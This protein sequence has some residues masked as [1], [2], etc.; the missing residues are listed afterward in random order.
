MFLW[1]ILMRLYVFDSP[2]LIICCAYD[3][4]AIMIHLLWWLTI[5]NDLFAILTHFLF[6]LTLDLILWLITSLMTAFDCAWLHSIHFFDS[7]FQQL[8]SWLGCDSTWQSMTWK[9]LSMIIYD[10]GATEHDYA[11][12]GS[13]RAW[14]HSIHSYDSL[15]DFMIHSFIMTLTEE[16]LM[17]CF[18]LYLYSPV[19]FLWSS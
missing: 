3:S 11:W 12:L 14:L 18:Y 15:F 17:L 9:W 7:L 19:D 10:L 16:S 4:F 8:R 1:H 5:C 13:D 2:W 6:W